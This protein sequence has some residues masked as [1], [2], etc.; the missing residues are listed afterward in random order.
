MRLKAK[1]RGPNP[2]PFQA[3]TE[4]LVPSD[5]DLFAH[6]D[7]F[8]ADPFGEILRTEL[9]DQRFRSDVRQSLGGVTKALAV[10]KPEAASQA[11]R[12]FFM[13]VSG[14]TP[15]CSWLWAIMA[16]INSLSTIPS[17]NLLALNV[18]SSIP[19]HI[20]KSM[21]WRIPT[22]SL[23]CILAQLC[24]QRAHCGPDRDHVL[25]IVLFGDVLSD[26]KER[27]VPSGILDHHR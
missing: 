24:C 20:S 19:V 3:N 2:H 1:V 7:T 9:L 21:S 26:Q 25:D 4:E 6:H 12:P 27:L 18:W 8:T 10:T 14:G 23:G 22:N 11:I 13:V 17:S 16:S 5:P 15:V